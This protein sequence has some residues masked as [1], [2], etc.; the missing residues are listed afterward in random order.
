MKTIVDYE[1][2]EKKYF[3]KI[4]LMRDERGKTATD[5]MMEKESVPKLFSISDSEFNR[6]RSVTDR[7]T[8]V[9]HS[10]VREL[11]KELLEKHEI[12]HE[13]LDQDYF[14]GWPVVP[15]MAVVVDEDDNRVLYWFKEFGISGML[16][17]EPRTA[18]LDYLE[19]DDY[20]YI[21]M[22]EKDAYKPALNHNNDVSDPSRGTHLYSLKWFFDYY[23]GEDEYKS[24][25]KFEEHFSERVRTYIGYTTV[26]NLTPN[27]LFSFK[28]TVEK[29]LVTRDYIK[30]IKENG[31][32]EV[33]ES[34]IEAIREQFIGDKMYLALLSNNK[35]KDELIR[36]NFAESFITAECLYDSLKNAGKLDY[37][38]ITLGYYKAMEQLLYDFV[39]LHR[40]EGRLITK[41]HK[42]ATKKYEKTEL[43]DEELDKIDF[44]LNSLTYFMGG[45][46]NLIRY[47]FS[48]QTRGYIV[49]QI[50]SIP[51]LR[52]GYIHK[53]NLDYDGCWDEVKYI[54]DKTILVAF[55]L[56]GAYKFNEE[57]KV[58][59]GVV[60]NMD[61][62][63][64][65]C[66]YTN[67]HT[68]AV[69][70][71]GDNEDNLFTAVA[72]ADENV[73]YDYYG[74][75]TYS[76]VYVSKMHDFPSTE[77]VY[78][79]DMVRN[80]SIQVEIIKYG[81]EDVP[82]IIYE[83]EMLPRPEGMM[84]SGPQRLLFK[85]GRFMG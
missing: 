26:K 30:L 47:G 82:F 76:G 18:L 29:D 8:E 56:L 5:L 67:Y 71:I 34:E 38:A 33:T 9:C 44:M 50:K 65:L 2:L 41:L 27:A 15:I 79:P 20:R 22:V 37:T 77:A 13:V 7:A 16:P 32:E 78:T 69:Y 62:Y 42:Y 68:G 52:N 45:N 3:S 59:L 24:F 61:D 83:G 12:R 40:G 11:I 10:L 84:F 39:L 49:Q 6:Y 51:E 75:A 23:F 31:G 80:H 53:D 14:K 21:C 19:A 85:N 70:Y 66:D 43:C 54:R 60:D 4:A 72:N 74:N 57:D 64:K 48:K 73:E 17:E 63:Y 36:R 58:E 25:A 1:N 55:L 35:G 28:K 46:Y 81:K